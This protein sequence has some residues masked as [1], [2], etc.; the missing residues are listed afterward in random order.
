MATARTDSLRHLASY[1]IRPALVEAKLITKKHAGDSVYMVTL[2]EELLSIEAKIAAMEQSAQICSL[3]SAG[4]LVDDHKPEE[5]WS[6][7]NWIRTK[8]NELELRLRRI[9]QLSKQ[10]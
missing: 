8:S 6:D 10:R 3:A 4:Q 2:A 5:E 7:A 9:E 1:V